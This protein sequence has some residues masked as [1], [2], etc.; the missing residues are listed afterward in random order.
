LNGISE[1]AGTDNTTTLRALEFLKNK[2]MVSI[3]VKEKQIVSLGIN[4]VYYQKRGLPERKLLDALT[5]R[6]SIPLGEIK[7]VC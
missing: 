7:N 4:G 3:D 2:N 6:K 1:R 5:D